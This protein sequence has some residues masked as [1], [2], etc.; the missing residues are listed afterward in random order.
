VLH[1]KT[2]RPG[3]TNMFTV[4]RGPEPV[5]PES[6]HETAKILYRRFFRAFLGRPAS[7]RGL[8]QQFAAS[9]TACTSWMNPNQYW[10]VRRKRH[11]CR[12]ALRTWSAPPKADAT[13]SPGTFRRRPGQGHQPVLPGRPFLEIIRYARDQTIDLI[14]SPPMAG[15]L[16]SM[17]WA[18]S[19]KRSSAI[20]CPVLT[21]RH[22]EY[23]F[24]AP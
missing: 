1:L 7:R 8:T 3:L 5:E 11:G 10:S 24:E 4:R 6:R 9:C 16:T 15:A 20:P 23:K 12:P 17:L 21:V 14:S 13:I 2:C 18:A 22:P 19:P